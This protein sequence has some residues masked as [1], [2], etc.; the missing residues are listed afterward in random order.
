MNSVHKVCEMNIRVPLLPH[1]FF[2]N[3]CGEVIL[4]WCLS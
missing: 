1:I 4:V 2:M 3:Q